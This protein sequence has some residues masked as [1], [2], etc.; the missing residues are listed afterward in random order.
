M[1]WVQKTAEELVMSGLQAGQRFN[2]ATVSLGYS[3]ELAHF[4]RTALSL[5]IRGEIGFI[6][7]T[8]EPAYGT[9]NPAGI[10]VFI[11]LRP[12]ASTQP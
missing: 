7:T 4:S 6:P 1:T 8:L 9:R 12:M 3:R 11:R 10:A 2:I 5:G